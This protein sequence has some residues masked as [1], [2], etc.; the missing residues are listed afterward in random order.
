MADA[1]YSP[2]NPDSNSPTPLPA[3]AQVEINF[4]FASVQDGYPDICAVTPPVLALHGGSTVVSQLFANRLE[5]FSRFRFYA[6]SNENYMPD[7][8]TAWYSW[9]SGQIS[10]GHSFGLPSGGFAGPSDLLERIVDP[11][12]GFPPGGYKTVD[13]LNFPNLYP[14]INH[15]GQTYDLVGLLDEPIHLE[16]WPTEYPYDV[17]Y[18]LEVGYNVSIFPDGP[19]GIP[20]TWVCYNWPFLPSDTQRDPGNIAGIIG[21]LLLI[22]MTSLGTTSARQSR[23]KS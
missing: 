16:G 22:G 9:S 15:V 17:P 19:T 4:S 23:S 3:D 6:W 14:S 2:Y 21:S 13:V 20:L 11:V 1:P 10:G 18:R 5:W 12:D 8:S 7:P